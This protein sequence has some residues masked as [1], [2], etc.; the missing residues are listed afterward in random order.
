MASEEAMKVTCQRLR[1]MVAAHS[2]QERLKE[3][4]STANRTR[5]QSLTQARARMTFRLAQALTRIEITRSRAS[6]TR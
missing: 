4:D 2:H 3:T 5:G 6:A 1:A